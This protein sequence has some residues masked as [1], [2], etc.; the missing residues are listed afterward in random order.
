MALISDY[1]SVPKRTYT[2]DSSRSNELSLALNVCDALESEGWFVCME[3]PI[4]GV[5]RNYRIPVFAYKDAKA[6]VVKPVIDAKKV[7]VSG[8]KMLDIKYSLDPVLP[9]Y[10]VIPVVYAFLSEY[11][12]AR[13]TSDD[14]QV[15]LRG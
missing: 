2:W 9:A 15:W 13:S 1:G 8:L 4:E 7:N 6:I 5:Q 12:T 14:Y 3:S 10:E 11:D